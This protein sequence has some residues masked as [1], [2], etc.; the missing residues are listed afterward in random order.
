MNVISLLFNF[1]AVTGFLVACWTD[2]TN[3]FLVSIFMVISSIYWKG[4]NK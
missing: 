2:D 1:A 3:L 4:G